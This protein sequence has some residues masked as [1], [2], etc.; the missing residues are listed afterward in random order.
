MH[1]IKMDSCSGGNGGDNKSNVSSITDV[2]RR[3]WKK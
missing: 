2:N 3:G 1:K